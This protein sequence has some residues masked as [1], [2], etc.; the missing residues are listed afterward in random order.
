MTDASNRLALW[1]LRLSD[2]DFEIAFGQ[3]IKHLYADAL[4]RILT[5]GTNKSPL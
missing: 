3:G 5:N 1:I 4:S 2:F